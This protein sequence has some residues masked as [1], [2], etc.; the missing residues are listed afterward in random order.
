MASSSPTEGSWCP[1]CKAQLASFQR[2]LPK[3]TEEGIS[4]IAFSADDEQHARSTLDQHEIT[5]P[6]GYGVDAVKTAEML[7]G[8]LNRARAALE[9]SNYFDQT[10]PSKLPSTLRRCPDA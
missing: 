5:F 3:L 1:Y 8:Y 7:R 6:I 4:V 2:H 9:S 10:A